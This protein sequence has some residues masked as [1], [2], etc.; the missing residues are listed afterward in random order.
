MGLAWLTQLPT[1]RISCLLYKLSPRNFKV[2]NAFVS[3]ETGEAE[4]TSLYEISELQIL[5]TLMIFKEMAQNRGAL[6]PHTQK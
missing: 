6:Y 3:M 4:A 2:W 1:N 5:G